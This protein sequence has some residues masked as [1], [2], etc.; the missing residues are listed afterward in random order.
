MY[1]ALSF[2]PLG[3]RF[4]TALKVYPGGGNDYINAVIVVVSSK[5]LVSIFIE[6]LLMKLR[7]INN[8]IFLLQGYNDKENYILTQ[9]PLKETV[10]DL[11]RLVN[12]YNSSAIVMLNQ[13]TRYQV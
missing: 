5:I 13:I 3:D 6:N 7:K 1:T 12:D 9:S 11:W 8:F 10:A 4:R 2:V